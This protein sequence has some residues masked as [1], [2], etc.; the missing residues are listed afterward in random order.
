LISLQEALSS[1]IVIEA[2]SLTMQG[3]PAEFEA[4]GNRL[5]FRILVDSPEKLELMWKGPR[6]PAFLCL[7]IALLLL[8]VSVPIT[9]AV[10]LNGF[11]SRAA[12]LWYFPLMNLVLF[13]IAVYLLAQQRTIAIDTP[14]RALALR[15]RHLFKRISLTLSFDEIDS[16]QIVPDLVY[17]GFAV[18]GSSAAQSFPVPSL[19]LAIKG[20]GSVLLDRGGAR[21]LEGLGEKI[22]RRLGV[23]LGKDPALR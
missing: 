14:M 22:A 15:K 2:N 16:I 9:Q 1:L 11:A 17:S 23:P 3:N 7:G 10:Y 20:R 8:F 18:A 12:S 5:G 4:I 21:R 19:R 13:G 6:F